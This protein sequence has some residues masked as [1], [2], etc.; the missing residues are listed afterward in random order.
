MYCSYKNNENIFGKY[1]LGIFPNT[2]IRN[3]S[4]MNEKESILFVVDNDTCSITSKAQ[5]NISHVFS[6]TFDVTLLVKQASNS[7]KKRALMIWVS[8]V[9]LVLSTVFI[10]P[11]K[12]I[13]KWRNK[14]RT[15]CGIFRVFF[16]C[17]HRSRLICIVIDG[18]VNVLSWT[19]ERL[20]GALFRRIGKILEWLCICICFWVSLCVS[21]TQSIHFYDF[22]SKCKAFILPFSMLAPFQIGYTIQ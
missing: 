18:H 22:S 12:N 10:G 13:N 7:S 17:L 15:H 11:I 3:T 1:L 8:F 2:L 21:L 20:A 9:S 6:C 16:T 14:Q 5:G 19:T 4:F